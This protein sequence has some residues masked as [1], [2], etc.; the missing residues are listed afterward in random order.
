MIFWIGSF[1]YYCKNLNLGEIL[2]DYYR[3]IGRN[4]LCMVNDFI[5]KVLYLFDKNDNCIK[6]FCQKN[7]KEMF[8]VKYVLLI[9]CNIC[10]L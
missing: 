5:F 4:K 2:Y 3:S 10:V 6:F 8:F 7:L 1:F 9:I